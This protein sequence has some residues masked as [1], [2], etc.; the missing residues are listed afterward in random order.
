MPMEV[1][2]GLSQKNSYWLLGATVFSLLISCYSVERECEKFHEGTF[3]FSAV[4]NGSVKTSYFVRTKDLE[5]ETYDGKIDTAQ[6][7][8]VNN[9]ECILTKINPTSNQ[10]KRPVQIKILSTDG[11]R[12]TF[13]YS[14]VG[15]A[16]RKQRGVIRKI[17]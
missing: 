3:E 10:D 12:Y 15:Q 5:I 2:R 17:D 14:M 11:D 4:L 8:W 1:L 9:C 6:I 7:R 13:E 16:D